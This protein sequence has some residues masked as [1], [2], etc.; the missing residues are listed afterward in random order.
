MAT[1]MVASL[2]DGHLRAATSSLVHRR[3]RPATITVAT[4]ELIRAGCGAATRGGGELSIEAATDGHRRQVSSSDQ[5]I[6]EIAA[7]NAARLD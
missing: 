1:E 3:R 4:C 7:T 5:L 6:A 2:Q